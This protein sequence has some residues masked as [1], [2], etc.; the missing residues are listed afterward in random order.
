LSNK[1]S[2]FEKSFEGWNGQI[3]VNSSQLQV[4]LAL[5]AGLDF[6]LHGCRLKFAILQII[7]RYEHLD[8]ERIDEINCLFN[9]M[10]L[11]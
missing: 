10:H 1:G 2:N 8:M 11:I 6:A 3:Q 9:Q 5:I 4:L 7:L